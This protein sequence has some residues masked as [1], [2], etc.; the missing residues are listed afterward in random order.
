MQDLNDFKEKV[1]KAMKEMKN[2]IK[3]N[4]NKLKE[5]QVVLQSK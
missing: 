1:I 4:K 5:T 2:E 3:M